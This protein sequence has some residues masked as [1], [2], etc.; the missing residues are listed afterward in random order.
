MRRTSSHL[1]IVLDEY[2]GTAGI[3]TMEDL[4]EELVG[5][6]TDEYDVVVEHDTGVRGDLV[7]DGLSTLDEFGEK[8]GFVLPPGPYDTV[9]GYFMAQLGQLPA[10]GDAIQASVQQV[11]SAEG[12]PTALELKVTELDGRR[13]AAFVVHRMDGGEL[14]SLPG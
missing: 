14:L 7:V 1:A 6:I 2:G 11:D 5:D 4:V 13:A 9:A 10:V 8:T 12:E 3:V